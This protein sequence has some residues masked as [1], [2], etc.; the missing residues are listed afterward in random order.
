M[1]AAMLAVIEFETEMQ[2]RRQPTPTNANQRQPTPFAA[3]RR[4]TRRRI[5]PAIAN[6]RHLPPTNA[7]PPPRHRNLPPANA[8]QR[9]LPRTSTCQ[10]R[11]NAVYTATPQVHELFD[12]IV[13]TSTGGLLAL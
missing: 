11:A 10:R 9:H 3:N 2:V 1:L 5:L 7:M 12:M 13:G 8:S 6:Q 4:R